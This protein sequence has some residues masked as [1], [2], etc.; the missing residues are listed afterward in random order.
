MIAFTY[1]GANIESSTSDSHGPHIFKISSQIHHL[2]GSLSLIDNNP[3][4]FAQLYIYDTENEIENRM[5]LF[6]FD[7]VS[8][9][10]TKLIVTQL[11]EMLDQTNKLVKLFRS[12]KNRFKYS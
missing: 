5:S 10:L 7:N 11:I 8:Q 3:S 9:D 12:I 6:V 1:F 4:K 2:M